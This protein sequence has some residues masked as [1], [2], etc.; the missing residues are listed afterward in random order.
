MYSLYILKNKRFV[1]REINP[2]SSLAD[3][4]NA[5]VFTYNIFHLTRML[6][7]I[8][9]IKIFKLIFSQKFYLLVLSV[10]VCQVHLTRLLY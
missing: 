7:N 4:G 9:A 6:Q 5:V 8:L 10:K 3:N 2:S 1:S